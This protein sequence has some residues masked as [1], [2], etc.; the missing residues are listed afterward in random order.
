M[1]RWGSHNTASGWA[2]RRRK[3]R[4]RLKAQRALRAARAWRAEFPPT[5]GATPVWEDLEHRV[6]AL[7]MWLAFALSMAVFFAGVAWILRGAP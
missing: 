7:S 5:D 6:M 2:R 4:A 3:H 1:T